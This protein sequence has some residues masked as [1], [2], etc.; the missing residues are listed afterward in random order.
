MAP[1]AIFNAFYNPSH[2]LA[3]NFLKTTLLL[4]TQTIV[5]FKSDEHLDKNQNKTTTI[6]HTNR[7]TQRKRIP[8]PKPT[9]KTPR[10]DKL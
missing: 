1:N 4:T 2:N 9:P 3:L 7:T 6:K 10:L 5:G 8:I